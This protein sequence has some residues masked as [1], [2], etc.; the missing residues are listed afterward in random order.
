MYPVE[1]RAAADGQAGRWLWLVKWLLLVP[2]VLVL[3]VLWI[4]FVVLTLV[5]YVAILVTGRYPD[6]I[7]AF[8]VGVLRWTWRVGYYGYQV[9]GTDRYPP[10]T[11]ADV[12][13][14]PARLHIRQPA[15]RRRWL[16]LVAWLF[17][18]PHALI[19]G[20]LG[21]AT[22]T[23]YR[24]G[25]TIVTVPAGLVAVSVLIIGVTLMFTGRHP[26]G[27]YD[28]LIGVARWSIRV[29]AYVAQLTDA[30]P[31]FRLDQGGDE[32][33]GVPP[34]PYDR[35]GAAVGQTP[36]P[37]RPASTT[38]PTPAPADP[39]TSGYPS[40]ERGSTVPHP[41]PQS[42]SGGTA[43]R[44]AMLLIGVFLLLGSLLPGAAGI[45]ALAVDSQR[46]SAGYVASQ[47]IAVASPTAA[48]TA[49]GLRIQA[50]DQWVHALT[51]IGDIRV[52]AT[53]RREAPL[54][55]GVA[56]QT[57]VDAWLSGT[58]HD[59]LTN[60]YGT[61]STFHRAG[62]PVKAV[63]APAAQGFW[64]ATASGTGTVTL[65]WTATDGDFAV[66]MANADGSPVIDGTAS[67]AA[68]V[69]RLAPAGFG[70]LGA[71]TVIGLG[72]LLLIYLGAA[73]LGSRH[74]PHP[75][76]PRPTGPPP[77]PY[78]PAPYRPARRGTQPTHPAQPTGEVQPPSEVQPTREAQPDRLR[79][80]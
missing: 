21:G 55:L 69:P 4:A 79:A 54:F 66:V 24:S 48:V 35:P 30:Y 40:G 11:L 9:L 56:R 18:L 33:T 38:G 3:A 68:R 1:V 12:G 7:F 67:V 27:L 36:G 46:D 25:N 32:P 26:R 6:R 64:L 74:A 44:V 73:G 34:G 23:A 37:V 71:A 52:T 28:L 14:Y 31:P 77:P 72:G 42:A 16:P 80:A 43:G 76:G 29:T 75:P 45:A 51:G 15:A 17:A 57:D 58:A 10:F 61:G 78:R 59:E 60:P 63:T 49:E 41:A 2:H 70:L 5:A 50:G 8:N 62:G 19:L 65:T 47:Q 20:G 13:D 39:P 22:W 53:T